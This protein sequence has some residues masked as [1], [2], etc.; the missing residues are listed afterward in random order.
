MQLIS[1]NMTLKNKTDWLLNG[2]S[3]HWPYSMPFKIA[4]NSNIN[5]GFMK[6]IDISTSG[7]RCDCKVFLL[8]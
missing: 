3:L 6:S 2:T 1:Q 7:F 4:Y 8:Y 5:N